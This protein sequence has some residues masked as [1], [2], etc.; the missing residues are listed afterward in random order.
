MKKVCITIA[1][2]LLLS[3]CSAAP[4]F[5]TIGN[6]FGEGQVLPAGKL[7]F[8]APEDASAQVIRSEEGT[9]YFCEGYEIMVQTMVSGDVSR[10]V[11][12]V[13]GYDAGDLTVME[14]KLGDLYRYECT[15]LAAGENGD[16]IGRAVILDDGRYHYTLSVMAAAGD[17]G[18]LQ[19][20]WQELFSSV[21]IRY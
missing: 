4:T 21:E 8:A 7:S 17:A 5:E 18:S 11:R 12:S 16:Q 14:T 13:T 20:S 19:E 15:W 2:L 9:L 3:G 6:A 10:T 1:L